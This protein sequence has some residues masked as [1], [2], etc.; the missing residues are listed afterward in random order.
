MHWLSEGDKEGA[1]HYGLF[2]ENG[3]ERQFLV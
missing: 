3:Y 2:I 1:N